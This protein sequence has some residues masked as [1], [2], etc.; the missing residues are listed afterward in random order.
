[1]LSFPSMEVGTGIPQWDT[2]LIMFHSMLLVSQSPILPSWVMKVLV[3]TIMG[4][5]FSPFFFFL[6]FSFQYHLIIFL[7]CSW[8]RPMGL[9]NKDNVL[10]V[11]SDQTGQI[12]TIS[13][14]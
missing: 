1:M 5:F 11:S 8:I 13:P 9:A 4:I 6:S 7:I 3:P 2:E 12:I 14:V 10:Y